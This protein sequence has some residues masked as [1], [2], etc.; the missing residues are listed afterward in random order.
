MYIS[1]VV[2]NNLMHHKYECK[3]EMYMKFDL[4]NNIKTVITEILHK[5]E[6]LNF[7]REYNIIVYC[8]L[9]FYCYF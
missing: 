5:N 7:C 2:M 6:V 8:L 4:S 3:S 9:H 1:Y